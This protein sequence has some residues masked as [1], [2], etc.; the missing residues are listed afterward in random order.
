M[1]RFYLNAFLIGALCFAIVA[2][3]ESTSAV[4]ASEDDAVLA[5]DSALLAALGKG[6]KSA[7]NKLLDRDFTWVDANANERTRAQVLASPPAA[8]NADVQPKVRLYGDAAV[9]KADRGKAYVMRIWVKRGSAWR[10]LLYQEVTLESLPPNP[11]APPGGSTDCDNPCKNYPYQAKNKTE[12]EVLASLHQ[13][14]M[15][16]AFH[17]PESYDAGTADEF[18]VTISTSKTVFTKPDRL[19]LIRQQQKAGTPPG[20]PAP[21]TSAKMFN[22]GNAVV[23]KQYQTTRNGKHDV[24]TRMWTQQG[25]RW[26][27]L[28]SFETI[29]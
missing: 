11:P 6:D 20:I 24:N 15:G 3:G 8:E 17:D 4:A 12:K 13:V 29:G 14:I 16:L 9:V 10:A 18:E 21:V 2:A 19:A 26:L 5:A 28:F 22:L 25:D 23:L 27:Q 1:K 7:A